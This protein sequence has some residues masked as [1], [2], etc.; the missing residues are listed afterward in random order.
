MSDRT[1]REPQQA[2]SPT[3]ARAQGFQATTRRPPQGGGPFGM[4]GGGEKAKTFWPSA[5]RL[6]GRLRPEAGA[7]TLVILLGVVSVVFSVLGPKI[8]GNATN[9]IF[10]G[11]FSKQFPAGTTKA[12]IIR[13]LQ[14]NHQDQLAGV[15]STLD[16]HPGQGID[17]AALELTL[18][19]VLIFYVASSVFSW[20]QGYLLNAVTQRTVYRLR[21]D[22]ES[23]IHRLPLTYFDRTPR[24]ELLSRVT[25]D[26]DNISQSL[27]QTV[28]QM[29]VSVLTVL[30]V[31]VMMF[32]ISWVLAL[33]ALVTVPLTVALTAVIGKRAQKRFVAQWAATGQLNAQIEEGYTGHAL[34][35]VFGR[36]R[37]VE[38]AFEKKNQELYAASFGGQFV[39]G[40][41][42]PATMFIGNLIYV[43]IAVVG[44]LMIASGG[45]RIGDVQAF[46]QYARQFTQPLAQLSSMANLLQ[47]GVASAERVFELLDADEQL[48]DPAADDVESPAGRTGRL[49]FENVSFRYE[50]DK[51]LIDDLSLVAAP[52]ST[53]AVVGPTGAGKTTLVN[54]IMRFY[55]VDAGRI[56]VDGID[57]RRMTRADLRCRTGMVLQDTWL[58]Q[59]TIRD[60][61][62]Y[63]KPGA[64][65][66]EILAAAEAAYVD[67]FVHSLPDGYDTVLDDEGGN[68]SAGEKQLITIA[69]AFIAAPSV[70]I[71]DEATSSVDTRTEL[72][73]Q[74]AMGE[75]R[76][77]RTSFVI[78]HRLSTI[79]DADLILVMESGSIVEQGT[80]DEL[81][82]AGGAYARL[83]QAQFAAPVDAESQEASAGVAPQPALVGAP[84]T[85]GQIV[86]EELAEAAEDGDLEAP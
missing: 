5:R 58:F 81:L 62:A 48:P 1:P 61:I 4:Q 86:R 26:I 73:V 24:G 34:V 69:R 66:E 79:R 35:K 42:M 28:S 64:T 31:L 15:V 50:S 38:A 82:A 53:I 65:E 85:V 63:G 14:A 18:G 6:V 19:I 23:K 83:Y 32:S 12:E 10:E 59:G 52:G 8:L 21:R 71:L 43:A 9:L 49:A 29:V 22:V 2:T 45:I 46:I 72:L 75:L 47:S 68:V 11:F 30:G 70:L 84:P 55:E 33:I 56:T 13:R 3:P 67:R 41:I 17:F 25:N 36:H 27:Q 78:A 20:L 76:K 44:G 74:R 54:L 37:E 77:D 16:L 57:T 39:S 60:N 51:P 7:M 40:L 80:H